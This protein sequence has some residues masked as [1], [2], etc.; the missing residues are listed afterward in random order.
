ML[1]LHPRCS[2]VGVN[3]HVNHSK[4]TSGKWGDDNNFLAGREFQNKQIGSLYEPWYFKAHGEF[5]AE[6]TGALSQI[7]G[8]DAVRIKLDGSN[9]NAYATALLEKTGNNDAF[10]APLN[11]D[12]NRERKTRVQNVAPVTNAELLTPSGNA[13]LASFN[14]RYINGQGSSDQPFVRT[15]TDRLHHIAGYTA[16]AGDGLR[17]VYAIPAYNLT[18]E[19]VSYTAEKDADNTRVH[20]AK[21]KNTSTQEDP[22]YKVANTERFLKKDHASAVCAFVFAYRYRWPRLRGPYKRWRNER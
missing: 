6:H 5:S 17:Y 7:G 2:H 9:S 21:G 20:L 14:V 1:T 18:Q 10:P 3:L 11:A 19:E 22:D 8:N 12:V 16:T 4:E 13:M 15:T